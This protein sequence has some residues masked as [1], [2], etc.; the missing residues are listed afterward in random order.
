MIEEL[1][2]HQ[3]RLGE[4]TLRVRPEPLLKG[5]DVF[6]VKLGD[7]FLMSS[8]FTAAEE[9]LARICLEGLE[10]E[11]DVVVGGLG[12]GYTAAAALRNESVRHLTVIEYFDEV[13]D[14]HK[15]HLVPVG[16]ILDTDSRCNLVQGD[17]FELASNGFDS[18]DPS[19]QFDAV[20]LDIDHT[21][22]HHLDDANASFYTTDGLTRLRNQ[23]RPS[24]RFGLWSDDES[25]D[26]FVNLLSYVFGTAEGHNVRFPNPYTGETAVNAVYVAENLRG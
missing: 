9:E 22:E 2:Y 6:E 15:R 10:G 3:T 24:G 5:I 25:D 7:E 26:E 17:F 14:W 18:D 19:R 16:E 8:L 23:L 20:L 13:I 1:A 21:P 4:L 12:L 11:L